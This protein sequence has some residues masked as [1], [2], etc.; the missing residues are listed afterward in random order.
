MNIII[1]YHELWYEKTNRFMYFNYFKGK[2]Q[3]RIIIDWKNYVYLSQMSQKSAIVVILLVLRSFLTSHISFDICSNAWWFT[4]HSWL[5]NSFLNV[6]CCRW[7]IELR[8]CVLP[9]NDQSS[10]TFIWRPYL[11]LLTMI[12]SLCLLKNEKVYLPLYFKIYP[13]L[14]LHSTHCT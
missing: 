4:T 9:P 13:C 7:C 12:F 6:C 10:W 5:N 1:K 3:M 14:Q 2:N 8:F 11:F